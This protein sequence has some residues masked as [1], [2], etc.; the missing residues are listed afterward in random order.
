MQRHTSKEE[1]GALNAETPDLP[2][3][4]GVREEEKEDHK[5]P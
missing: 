1:Q 3:G 4:M 2:T 5:E